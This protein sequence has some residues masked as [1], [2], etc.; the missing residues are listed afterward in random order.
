[1]GLQQQGSEVFEVFVYPPH[2]FL[3]SSEFILVNK[4]IELNCK[5]L[6]YSSENMLLLS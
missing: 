3:K 4:W 6:Q 1:M 2:L 5:H